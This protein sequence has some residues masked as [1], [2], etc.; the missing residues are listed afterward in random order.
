MDFLKINQYL[1]LFT[2]IQIQY[3]INKSIIYLNYLHQKLY[4]LNNM[5][6]I[7]PLQLFCLMKLP[8]LFANLL[9]Y[10]LINCTA[11]FSGHIKPYLQIYLQ[12]KTKT[13]HLLNFQLQISVYKLKL[14]MDLIIIHS[15]CKN[16][17]C[18]LYLDIKF[19]SLK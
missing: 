18:E 8:I 16:S 19:H 6:H 17:N 2:T 7:L 10:L 1:E 13:H 4:C 5:H 15:S 11:K 3:N 14:I 12:R 9:F